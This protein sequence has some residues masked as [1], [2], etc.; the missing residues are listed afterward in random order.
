MFVVV[1]AIVILIVNSQITKIYEFELESLDRQTKKFIY[2]KRHTFH[3]QT[4]FETYIDK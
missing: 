2:T 3:I 1:V 4:L